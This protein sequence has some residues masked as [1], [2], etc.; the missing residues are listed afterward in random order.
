[1]GAVFYNETF[2][3]SAQG[4][5]WVLTAPVSACTHT[6]QYELMQLGVDTL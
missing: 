6:H 3:L 5:G 2:A 4:W 1:M